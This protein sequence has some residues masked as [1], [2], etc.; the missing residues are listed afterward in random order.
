MLFRN[1]L[2]F[3]GI[4]G[5]VSCTDFGQAKFDKIK[6]MT[7]DDMTFPNRNNMLKDLTTNHK[8]VGLK[9]NEA[10][11]LLGEPNYSDC[12]SFTYQVIEDYG[13]D[14]DPVYSKNL[15]FEFGKDSVITSYKIEVWKKYKFL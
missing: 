10:I 2:F 8:L 15:D 7:K 6:W 14:I 1:L 3:I 11:E 9:H 5:L 4:I 13:S 12:S